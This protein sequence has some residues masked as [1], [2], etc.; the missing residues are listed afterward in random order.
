[1]NCSATPPPSQC[2]TE[3]F[4]A[5]HQNIH[6]PL[7]NTADATP[8]KAIKDWTWSDIL[9]SPEQTNPCVRIPKKKTKATVPC[10]R[11]V[12]IGN[13]AAFS[14][15]LDEMRMF[16][17]KLG[18]RGSRKIR[19]DHLCHE[20][21]DAKGQ[22]DIGVANGTLEM[23][24]PITNHP[25]RFV[26]TR[27]LNVLFGEAMKPHLACRGRVLIRSELEEKL[28]T[29]EAMWKCF[30]SEY[31]TDSDIYVADAFPSLEIKQ[32]AGVFTKFP[33]SQWKRASDKFK[34]L[35]N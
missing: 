9:V 32:D 24:D 8:A 26:T 1:M 28:K 35:N 22:Y 14:I 7:D 2:P 29:Y 4:D 18:I 23:V 15:S 33:E 21:V 19:K 5:S 30:I 27:F 17:A 12:S 10:S 13:V 11:L 31:N 16:A 6:I 34:Q 25:I 20:I 3:A